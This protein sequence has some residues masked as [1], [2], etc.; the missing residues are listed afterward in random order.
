MNCR[1][2]GDIH[3]SSDSVPN[4]FGRLLARPHAQLDNALRESSCHLKVS[5]TR[6][7]MFSVSVPL[8]L[9]PPQIS[10]G[11]EAITLTLLECFVFP[12]W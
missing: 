12:R 9:L 8:I 3:H 4:T 1:F 5:S 11:P 6:Y 10:W 2:W 7:F